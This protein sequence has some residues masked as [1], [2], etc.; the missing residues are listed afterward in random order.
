MQ[1]KKYIG[2]Y[3]SGDVCSEKF[4]NITIMSEDLWERAQEVLR[5]RG[6]KFEES[7][8]ISRRTQGDNLLAGNIFCADCGSRLVFT[9]QHRS[10]TKKDGS[11][12]QYYS[13]RYVCSNRVRLNAVC[14]S[15]TSYKAETIE[16]EVIKALRDLF[17]RISDTPENTALDK[18]MKAKLTEAKTLQKKQALVLDKLNRQYE[19]L[20]LEIANTL[21]GDSI[22]SAEDLSL[23][24]KT[25]KEKILDAGKKLE[26]AT[27]EVEKANDGIQT[28]LP[29]Y[30]RFV[31]WA[32]AFDD[33]TVEEKRI[34][35]S[36]LIDR[37]EVNRG[38]VIDIALNMD[39][40]QF[41]GD[42]NPDLTEKK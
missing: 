12:V 23:A 41:C 17:S 16:D 18:K 5:Q 37:I 10:N 24:I 42:W 40:E 39:Y 3:V 21:T 13:R 19:K 28:V 35:I 36:N 22:Y 38:Y 34:V 27:K 15:A 7:R 14:K 9:A 32:A 2:Y 31:S 29:M 33:M 6:R 20:Q 4:D 26:E 1:N 25:I 8:T 11:V 30:K